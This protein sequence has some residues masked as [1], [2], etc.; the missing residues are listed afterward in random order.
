MTT[1]L[2]LGISYRGTAYQ[3]WQR[4]PGGRTVQDQV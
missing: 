1:R 2:A 4:Q 3:G